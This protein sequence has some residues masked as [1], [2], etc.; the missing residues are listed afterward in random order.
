M[1]NNDEEDSELSDFTN[2]VKLEEAE[3][4]GARDIVD[5][6]LGGMK[7]E[8]VECRKLD[9]GASQKACYREEQLRDFA[10]SLL[11]G[12]KLPPKKTGS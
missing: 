4:K 5:V 12:G 10:Q 11:L 6:M 1:I 3:A 9:G 2:P 8:G 7:F